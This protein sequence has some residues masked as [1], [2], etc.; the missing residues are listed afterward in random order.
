[1]TMTRPC[2]SW[3]DCFA[4]VTSPPRCWK[5]YLFSVAALAD[6]AGR[7]RLL[8]WASDVAELIG[9][10]RDRM[11]HW[12]LRS[13]NVLAAEREPWPAIGPEPM[14]GHLGSTCGRPWIP[15][16]GGSRGLVNGSGWSGGALIW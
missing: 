3:P 9:E 11:L 7:E 12:D 14:V 16:V 1:M 5:K 13:G 15:V 6:A 4:S 2:A 10:P 8:G